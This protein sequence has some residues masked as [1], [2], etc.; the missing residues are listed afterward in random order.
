MI[1]SSANADRQDNQCVRS[2]NDPDTS[3]H[4]KFEQPVWQTAQ[5]FVGEMGCWLVLALSKLFTRGT[6]EDGGAEYEPLLAEE[7][8]ESTGEPSGSVSA[9]NPATTQ[10]HHDGSSTT[11][12]ELT[13]WRTFLLAM[14]AICD[15][16]G[17]TLMNTGLLFVVASVSFLD[18]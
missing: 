16:I 4:E 17:T 12:K 8:E 5:M 15:I 13:G 9:T 10:A 14:P 11:V 7:G 1:C 6:K 3:K 18:E 2:C